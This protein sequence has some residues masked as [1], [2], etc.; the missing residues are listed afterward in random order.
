M[1][2]LIGTR[3]ARPSVG[4]VVE[5]FHDHGLTPEF[6][7]A[8][9]NW[10]EVYRAGIGNGYAHVDVQNELQL[11]DMMLWH[12]EWNDVDLGACWSERIRRDFRSMSGE[13]RQAWRAL[14][15]HIRGDGGSKPPKPWVKQAQRHLDAVGQS[16]FRAT[17]ADWFA[18]FRDR[19]PL[20]LSVVGS[21]V[22]KGLLWYCAVA[23]D[24]A[25]NAGA[26]PLVDATWKSKRSLDKVMVALAVLIDTM[27]VE[28]AWAALLPLQSAW[29]ASQGQI[30]RLVL[31]IAAAREHLPGGF[32]RRSH[33][34]ADAGKLGTRAPGQGP[35]DGRSPSLRRA[36]LRGAQG[37]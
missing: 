36:L 31:K 6:C 32:A 28:E 24:P 25:V 3:G 20:R 37:L 26:L 29:G 17:M 1:C 4:W 27:P 23:R 18:S 16:D 33:F 21:H 10:R 9:R 14:L 35:G 2:Q 30:E 12:D 19:E 7:A 34:E 13:R 15:H 8:L 11:I 22:L 5:Y